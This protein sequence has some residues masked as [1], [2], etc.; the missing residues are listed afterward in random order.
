MA[1]T[2]PNKGRAAPLNRYDLVRRA[3]AILDDYGIAD[4][5]MRRLAR[6]LD[7]AP[8][9]LYWHFANKQQ[10]LG[11]VA[12]HV[13]AP[14]AE[15]DCRDVPW[16]QRIEFLCAALRDALLSHKDGAELVS[17]SFASGQTSH[18]ITVV[19]RLAEAAVTSGLSAVPAA[20]AARSIVYYVLGYVADEQSRLQWDSA[21]ALQDGQSLL[22]DGAGL[23]D[24]T[25]QFGFGVR[26]LVDGIGQLARQSSPIS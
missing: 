17:A 13:L 25:A 10:L 20:L 24:P 16:Q 26:L 6:E 1:I 4:L 7:I 11:A 22:A 21:G 5:T 23:T 14:L 9:A 18:M 2:E 3:T 8:S 15:T 19:N 12:D